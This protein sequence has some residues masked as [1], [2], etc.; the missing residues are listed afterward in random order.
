MTPASRPDGETPA[1][2][3][4]RSYDSPVRRQQAADTHERILAAGSALVHEFPS[5]DWRGLTMRAVAERADVHVRTVYRHFATERELHDAVM[6]RLEAEAGVDLAAL[7]LDD[8]TAATRATFRYLASFPV[9]RDRPKDPTFA[10]TDDRRRTAVLDAVNRLTEGWP[11]ADRRMVA[12]ILDVL[13]C[14]PSYERLVTA[15]DLDADEA[16]DAVTWV[17]DLL[18]EAVRQG[19]PPSRRESGG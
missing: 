17:M 2:P 9:T 4:R 1:P 11:E 5:W 7:E 6:G 12:G 10:A 3:S 16:A 13:W 8:L 18:Q 19:R 14:L 15:W